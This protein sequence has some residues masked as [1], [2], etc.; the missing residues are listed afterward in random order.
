MIMA[1]QWRTVVRVRFIRWLLELQN[2]SL[3]CRRVGH[4]LSYEHHRRGY[5]RAPV[6]AHY[7]A[8]RVEQTRRL[9]PR[10]GAE[11]ALTE[12]VRI[13]MH[14]PTL[15]PWTLLKLQRVGVVW[16]V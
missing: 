6:G 15:L 16:G 13:L 1:A 14:M 4:E 3:T 2:P 8:I 10:C 7:A 12:T 9:C 5:R 11:L